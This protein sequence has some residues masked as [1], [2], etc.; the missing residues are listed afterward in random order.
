MPKVISCIFFFPVLALKST[1]NFMSFLYKPWASRHQL[2]DLTFP[3]YCRTNFQEFGM[4]LKCKHAEYDQAQV[5]FVD[6][7]KN[8]IITNNAMYQSMWLW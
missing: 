1:A 7:T 2:L 8:Y 3:F 5:L 6:I 4:T